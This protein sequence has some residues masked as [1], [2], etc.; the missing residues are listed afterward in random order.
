M[1]NQTYTTFFESTSITAT[2]ADASADVLYTVPASHDVEVTFLVCTNGSSTNKI[3]V[4]V[5]HADDTAYHHILRTH[6][7][8]GNDTYD[9]ITSNRLYLHAGDKVVVYKSGGTFDASISG[10]LM[11]NPKRT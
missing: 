10:K 5:Y 2:A 4:Q 6:S 7:V 11:Y 9:V 3:S 1:A 8:S